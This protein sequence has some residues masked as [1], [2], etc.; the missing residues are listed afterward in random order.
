[1]V[2]R[3]PSAAAP[4]A[5]RA[6]AARAQTQSQ[7]APGGASQLPLGEGLTQLAGGSQLGG[8]LALPLGAFTQDAL[9]GAS[10]GAASS[11]FG[12]SSAALFQG[13]TQ[14]ARPAPSQLNPN[15]MPPRIAAVRDGAPARHGALRP[16]ARLL[17]R[18]PQPV[19]ARPRVASSGH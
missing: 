1:M 14:T 8:P 9:G 4:S 5:Q 16:P 15:P 17:R 12:A 7:A 3:P 6:S 10:Q 13:F 18:C 11:R 19:R 2:A